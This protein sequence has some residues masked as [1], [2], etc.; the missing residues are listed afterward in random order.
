MP[1]QPHL[2]S[3]CLLMHASHE[4]GLRA[5]SLIGLS[6][7][8]IWWLPSR[9]SYRHHTAKCLPQRLW[10]FWLT[11]SFVLGNSGRTDRWS[12]LWP[13][14]RQVLHCLDSM[15]YAQFQFVGDT[16]DRN[17]CC[18]RVATSLLLPIITDTPSK[19]AHT[20]VGKLESA[21]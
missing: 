19:L 4:Y 20:K 9:Y 13:R 18:I 6:T 21:G 3:C 8:W 1:S 7:L 15:Q 11:P 17:D 5:G 10:Q 12:S 16:V 14:T 2:H